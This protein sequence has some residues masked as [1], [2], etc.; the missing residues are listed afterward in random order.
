MFGIKKEL[1]NLEYGKRTFPDKTVFFP[2]WRETVRVMDIIPDPAY[3]L[4]ADFFSV[5]VV[6]PYQ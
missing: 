3:D 1:D 4:I 5:H 2:V 6:P